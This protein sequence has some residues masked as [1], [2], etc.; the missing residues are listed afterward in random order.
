MSEFGEMRKFYLNIDSF[1][2]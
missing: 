1:Y 2:Y